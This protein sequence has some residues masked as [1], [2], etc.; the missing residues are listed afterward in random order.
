MRL[1]TTVGMAILLVGAGV[2][3]GAYLGSYRLASQGDGMSASQALSTMGQR[4]ESLVQRV[5][6]TRRPADKSFGSTAGA[7]N[8]LHVSS[9]PP[10]TTDNAPPPTPAVIDGISMRYNPYEPSDG[11]YPVLTAHEPGW[12]DASIDQQL[13]YIFDGNQRHLLVPQC[14]GEHS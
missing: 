4:V 10:V 11:P 14:P 2:G 12:V 9:A 7:G 6:G 3:A 5:M 8:E 1:K 13:I